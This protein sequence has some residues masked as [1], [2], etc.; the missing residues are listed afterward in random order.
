[1]MSPN[2]D[3]AVSGNTLVFEGR[4]WP[5]EA[6]GVM[7]AAGV[8]RSTSSSSRMHN[9]TWQVEPQKYFERLL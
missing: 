6:R 2:I 7:K 9:S 3:D 4:E 1:M 8:R 5:A